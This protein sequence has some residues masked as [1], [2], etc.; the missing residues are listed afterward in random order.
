VVPQPGIDNLI[1]T[2]VTDDNGEYYCTSL[3]A[4]QYIV[5]VAD[6]GDFDEAND[7]TLVTGNVG[8]NFAKNWSY[9]LTLSDS[10]PNFS[11]DF[12]VTGNNSLSGTVVI[13]D[14]SLVEPDDN[15]TLEPTE[16]DGSVG[17]NPDS[18]AAN[19]PVVLFVEQNGVFVPLLQTTTDASGNYQFDNLP[20]GNYRVVV[21][22]DGSPIDGFG[23]TGD[24]DLA[25]EPLPEDR[26]CDSLTSAVCDDTSLDY[27]LSGGANET[28]VNFAYQRNFATTPVTMNFFSAVRSGAVVEFNWETSNEVGH[29]GFQIY[30]RNVDD[31]VLLTPQLIVANDG[32]A[33]DTRSYTYQVA[34][35]AEWFALVDVS[36]Q[37]EVIPHGPFRADQSYG[38]N[39]VTPDEFDWAGVEAFKPSADE[40]R[41]SVD[42][43]IQELIR[44]GRYDDSFDEFEEPDHDAQ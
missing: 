11:A 10:A 40:T 33:M 15:G 42:K 19:V 23:Q 16:L 26:V 34:T 24:P 39:L 29:A 21:M 12:G 7:G 37:E 3:P 38:A 35:D 31:W 30:A 25:G 27:A 22:T 6:A 36:N 43:R 1:R 41:K 5:T 32:Q 2:V 8:D 13:E 17:G 4:G 9:A 20:D 44:S 28:G 14:E 18:P